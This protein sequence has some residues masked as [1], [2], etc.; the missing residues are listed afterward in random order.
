[1]R[2]GKGRQQAL[3]ATGEES[4][5]KPSPVA[6]AELFA[7]VKNILACFRLYWPWASGL[8]GLAARL[9]ARFKDRPILAG[10]SDSNPA[11]KQ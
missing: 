11:K 5:N 9:D 10:S 6:L 4:S 7:S 8:R 1:M 2:V 3:E